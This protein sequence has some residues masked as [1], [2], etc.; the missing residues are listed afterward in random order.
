MKDFLLTSL[1][2]SIEHGWIPDSMV[3]WGIR[4][5]CGQR[6]RQTDQGNCQAN[7]EAFEAFVNQSKLSPIAPVPEKA[8]EQHYE[9]PAAFY[10]YVLGPRLKYSS[11]VWHEGVTSLAQA[12]EDSLRETCQRAELRDGMEILELGC[13]WGSLTLWM[14]EHYPSSRVTAVSNSNSQREYILSRAKANGWADRLRVITADMNDFTTNAKFDRI[15][16][17][18]MF[19]HMR[20]HQE[21][22][23][24]IA[25]WMTADGKLFV[26]VFCHREFAY[27][28]LPEG[29]ANW[30]GKYFFTGGIM[31]SDHLFYHY[32]SDLRVVR[33]WRWSG[34]DYAKTANAW[35]DNMDRNQAD[36][37][38][39]LSTIYGA[40]EA[41]VWFQRWRLLFMAGAEL[42]NYR[43]GNEWY[44]SHYLFEPQTAREPRQPD[45]NRVLD[46][47][48]S[49]T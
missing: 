46:P 1:I 18:E 35:I 39:I 15:M 49:A 29:T 24:R 47:S 17:V 6:L 21:L 28:F 26:H 30:M 27:E 11:C 22:L 2:D 4:R 34:T 41:K 3:R 36:L 48:C 37:L 40:K 43:G 25:N 31:P 12:E 20:N 45:P 38:P 13:G 7:H 33:Q 14:L 19:E 16:S 23:K 5:L 9:V 8:N 42:F 44:V 32:A 10:P